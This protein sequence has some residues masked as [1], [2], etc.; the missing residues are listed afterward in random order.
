MSLPD[1]KL[2]KKALK[3]GATLIGGMDEVGRGAGFG[4]L[5]VAVVILQDDKLKGVVND[6]KL[7]SKSKRV[8]I[9]KVIEEEALAIGIGEVTAREINKIGLS[10]ALTLAGERA[11]TGIRM[12]P[13]YLLLDGKHNFLETDIPVEM[14]IKGDRVSISIASAS[15]IAKVYRDEKV[16]KMSKKFKGYF[17]EEN[18][19]YATPKHKA[20]VKELGLTKEHRS[21]WGWEN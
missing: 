13:N 1:Y 9:A 14:V 19:G 4:P 8:K 2:E 6:S 15:I 5:V 7:I 18:M 20:K 12:L 11:I 17:L 21:N 16:S 3:K 10:R